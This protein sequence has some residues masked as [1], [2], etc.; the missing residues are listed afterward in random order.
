MIAS[1]EI[2]VQSVMAECTQ[3][4][5]HALGVRSAI[6]QVAKKNDQILSWRPDSEININGIE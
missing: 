2:W 3:P 4:F 5:D 1:Q 6:D